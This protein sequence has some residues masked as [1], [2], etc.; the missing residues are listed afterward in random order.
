M[1]WFG[2]ALKYEY[3][4]R[5]ITIFKMI[6]MKAKDKSYNLMFINKLVALDFLNL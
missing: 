5:K 2:Y 6:I 4:I 1:K 3:A